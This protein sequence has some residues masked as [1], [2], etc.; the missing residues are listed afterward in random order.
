MEAD[1][2]SST[3]SSGTSNSIEQIDILLI[4]VVVLSSRLALLS[5]L[6]LLL[7]QITIGYMLILLESTRNYVDI[8][9]TALL[10]L[11]EAYNFHR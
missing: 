4:C 6:K 10:V 7:L 9:T 5:A 11:Q 8:H 2:A 1:V 3:R